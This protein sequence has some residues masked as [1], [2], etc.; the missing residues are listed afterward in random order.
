MAY[1]WILA[2]LAFVILAYLYLK[3][4]LGWDLLWTILI[5]LA[6]HPMISFTIVFVV[7][8]FITGSTLYSF[9]ISFVY[10]CLILSYNAKK[11]LQQATGID[12][13]KR[14]SENN[15]DLDFDFSNCNCID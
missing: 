10:V 1:L 7:S 5:T 9:F 3:D 6:T 11:K 15:K 2:G 14:K 8:Y 4:I 12:E 13:K